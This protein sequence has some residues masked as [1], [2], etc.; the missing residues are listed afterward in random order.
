MRRRRRRRR[1]RRRSG[2]L[3]GSK[4]KT[5]TPHSDVGNNNKSSSN[6]NNN[7]LPGSALTSP[8][9]APSSP[10]QAILNPFSSPFKPPSK[11]SPSS[12]FKPFS[13][14]SQGPFKPFSSPSQAPF[15]AFTFKPPCKPFSS[16]LQALLKPPSSPSQ[17]A[18]EAPFKLQKVKGT[19]HFSLRILPAL[20]NGLATRLE[21]QKNSLAFSGNQILRTKRFSTQAYPSSSQ[22]TVWQLGSRYNIVGKQVLLTTRFNT[23]AL[24]TKWSSNHFSHYFTS[25]VYVEGLEKTSACCSANRPGGNR[26]RALPFK[27]KAIQ[28]GPNSCNGTAPT[29]I[30]AMQG[31]TQIA[32]RYLSRF[33]SA[34]SM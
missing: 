2:A 24:L 34:T 22:K 3:A 5:R 20:Q 15:E 25:W 14:P 28:N 11:P 16:P 12:S 4:R 30:L 8:H 23:Q 33:A 31:G 6:N 29:P 18:L 27:G 9:H 1:G 17:A 10:S 7:H 21:L 13:S 32:C 26:M 19:V